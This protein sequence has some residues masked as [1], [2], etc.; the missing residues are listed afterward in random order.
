MEPGEPLSCPEPAWCIDPA[1]M[2]GLAQAAAFDLD[3]FISWGGKLKLRK[4][5]QE[6]ALRII[7]SIRC[8]QGHTIVV[9]FPRQSGKNELQAQVEAYLLTIFGQCDAEM[10]KVSPTW[11]PQTLN[12]MRRLQRVLERNMLVW[13]RWVKESGYVYRLGRARIFFL[14]GSPTTNVVGATASTLLQCDEAQDVLVSKWDKDFSPMAAS[15]NATRVFWGTAWTSHSL[16]ARERRAAEEAE[17]QDGKRRV[18]VIDANEVA[19]EVPAYGDFVR[20]QVAKLGRN[21]P[22]VKTQFFGEEIDA[23]GGMFPAARLALMAGEHQEL[24]APVAGR[25]YAAL[26][27]VAGQDEGQATNAWLGA[28]SGAG[29]EE[30]RLEN[31][32]RDSTAMTIVEVDLATL[33]DPLIKAPAYRV[34]HRRLWTGINHSA[35]YGQLRAWIQHWRARWVVIDATGVGAGLSSFLERAFPGRVL[36]FLFSQSSKSKLGWDFLGVIDSGRFK[37]YDSHQSLPTHPNPSLKGGEMLQELFIRQAESCQYQVLPGPGKVLR[38]SVPDGYRDPATG[39][40]LH[41]DLLMSAALVAVLDG[42]EWAVTG[43]ALIVPRADP[44]NEM[45]REGF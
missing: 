29:L 27:D 17:R 30:T 32:G 33:A 37:D 21:H 4:Y 39:E 10:V 15:T 41:D 2:Q 13:D 14:S 7:E 24:G 5:Q 34:V 38:W 22:M 44:L 43:P 31:P 11:K 36:P 20:Q 6:V 8:K 28:G 45:D 42:Q 1:A 40:L 18:F 26:I 9:Q 25:I 3:R 19:Q 23:E 16:L 35:L 12:A